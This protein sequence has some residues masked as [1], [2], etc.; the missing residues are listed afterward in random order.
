MI[1]RDDK[2]HA[3]QTGKWRR[4]LGLVLL[5]VLLLLLLWRWLPFSVGSKAVSDR[6]IRC[7]AEQ[8]R[9]AYFVTD[10]HQFKRG[11][12]QSKEM[13]FSGK[14]SCKVPEGEGFQFGITY[15]LTAEPGS[16]YR[17]RVWRY[18]PVQDTRSFLVLQSEDKELYLAQSLP[19]ERLE[20]G[21]ERLELQFLSPAGNASNTYNV[22]VFTNGQ[23]PVYFDDLEIERIDFEPGEGLEVEVLNLQ[24]EERHLA[25][26]QEKRAEA[27]RKG[28]LVSGEGD[29]VRA[30]LHSSKLAQPLEVELRLKGDLL[31]HLSVDKW[32]FRVKVRDDGAWRSLHTFSLQTPESRYFL[33]EWLLHRFWT[34]VDVLTTR[35]DFVELQLN[36]KSLGVYAYEEHFEKQLLEARQRSEGP[37]V[38]LEESGFWA[39]IQRQLNEKGFAST[40]LEQSVVWPETADIRPFREGKT[41]KDMELQ[42]QYEQAMTLMEQLRGGA[43]PASEIFDL[44]RVAR[45]FAVLDLFGAYHGAIWSNQRFYYNPQLNQ[46]EPVGYD[47]FGAAPEP[48]YSFLG[49]GLTHPDKLIRTNVFATCF[50]D[51]AFVSRY[52]HYLWAYSQEAYLADFLNRHALELE[53][54]QAMLAN[55]FEY[56]FEPASWLQELRGIRSLI[57]PYAEHSVKTA[58]LEQRPGSQRLEVWNTHTLP[59]EIVSYSNS[60]GGPRR[61]LAEPLYLTAYTPREAWLQIRLDSLNRLEPLTQIRR[62]AAQAAAHQ[63]RVLKQTL[64]LPASAAYL[65]IRLPGLDS[66]FQSPISSWRSAELEVPSQ[67]LFRSLRLPASLQVVQQ[68]RVLLIPEGEYT[69]SEPFG[70]PPGYELHLAAGVRIDLIKG[71]FIASRSPVRA[72][73]SE[74]RPIWIYSS[75]GRGQGLHVWQSREPS[76]LHRVVFDGLGQLDYQGWRLSGAVT[77]Y[78]TQVELDA[79]VFK[80][81]RSENGLHLVRTEFGMDRCQV[82]HAA[83]DGLSLDF[84]RG[85]IRNSRF[86]YMGS[87]GINCLGSV[88]QVYDCVFERNGDKA[89]SAGDASDVTLRGV[90]IRYSNIGVAS[91]DESVVLIE[92]IDLEACTQG[93]TAYQKKPEYGPAHIV[94]QAYKAVDV[95]RLYVL[96]QGSTLQL[97]EQMMQ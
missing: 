38:R 62:L 93:F 90:K 95:L 13:A 9:G 10:G 88:V 2:K 68:G 72:I 47:G 79:C 45:Y 73:G 92:S 44:E 94:V 59:L 96:F 21:W 51:T 17:I 58:V 18:Q 56:R 23:H 60:K 67:A 64:E 77:F 69:L 4:G 26:L 20:N 83:S 1:L 63:A 28:L 8:V 50:L 35:Y 54:R 31:D 84:S 53:L 12:L 48:R 55:E 80:N 11:D 76:V 42:A 30:R 29:W 40:D 49:Q 33:H 66:I 14:Y 25:K 70:I 27:L 36:G 16:F 57:L 32:S 7:D 43:H 24:I 41:G 6:I 78:E 19:A 81:N 39:G 89:L 34:E 97:G 86:A 82:L 3:A 74:E 87:D 37:I 65:Y 52:L 15:V 91:K 22:Y 85:V 71:A 61:A 46:L 5:A 75:D